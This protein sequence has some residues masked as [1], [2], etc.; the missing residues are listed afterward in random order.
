[1]GYVP[2]VI[3]LGI[4]VWVCRTKCSCRTIFN[5]QTCRLS[6]LFNV[7]SSTTVNKLYKHWNYSSILPK[8]ALFWTKELPICWHN[9]DFSHCPDC[10]LK[11]YFA[12][13]F[14]GLLPLAPRGFIP[15]PHL[16]CAPESCVPGGSAP[17]TSFGSLHGPHSSY[18]CRTN[19][20]KMSWG[21]V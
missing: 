8:T 21:Y 16:G 5:D 14:W 12:R 4:W 13:I 17:Q 9:F 7:F 18:V 19:L 3:L 11:E 10:F 20:N 1:M 15:G 2:Q 6:N